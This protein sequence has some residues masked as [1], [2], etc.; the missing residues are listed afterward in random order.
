MAVPFSR[1]SPLLLATTSQ[2]FYP[3]KLEGLKKVLEVKKDINPHWLFLPFVSTF[4]S[5]LP[6]HLSMSAFPSSACPP[7]F[8]SQ[9]N[10]MG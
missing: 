6:M 5:V 1:R 8:N 3:P 10:I 7:S 2:Q 9:N 4:V